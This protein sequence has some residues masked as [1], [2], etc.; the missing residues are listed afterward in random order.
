[1]AFAVT[2]TDLRQCSD[3]AHTQQSLTRGP[4]VAPERRR[5]IGSAA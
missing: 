2:V 4:I 1:M 3:S 5:L